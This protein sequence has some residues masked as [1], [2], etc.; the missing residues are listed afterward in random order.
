VPTLVLRAVALQ[1]ALSTPGLIIMLTGFA[2]EVVRMVLLQ[3]MMKVSSKE[4]R[5]RQAGCSV[6]AGWCVC[7]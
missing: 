7:V 5:G 2:I 4:A 1:V 3:H 6:W